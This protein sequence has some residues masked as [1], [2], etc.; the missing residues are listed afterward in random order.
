MAETDVEKP[1][2]IPKKEL[3]KS[4]DSEIDY[5][6]RRLDWLF[7]YSLAAQVLAVTGVRAVPLTAPVVAKI[8]YS[9]FFVLI[10]ALATMFRNS[11]VHRSYHLRDR[12]AELAASVGYSDLFTPPGGKFKDGTKSMS[13]SKIYLIA[14][15]AMSGLGVVITVFGR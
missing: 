4:L 14:V 1:D 2:F 5:Y 12:R 9:A 3:L 13:P 6:R 10:A 7:T 8:V 15:W 11:Y